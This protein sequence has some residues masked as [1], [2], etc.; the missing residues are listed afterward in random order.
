MIM[1]IKMLA[2]FVFVLSMVFCPVAYCHSLLIEV[3][4]AHVYYK[5]N[6]DEIFLGKLLDLAAD[7]YGKEPH[8]NISIIFDSNIPLDTALNASGI[9]NKAGFQKVVLFARWKKTEKMC[10][11]T[12]G[13]PVSFK[14]N[15]APKQ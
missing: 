11:V 13:M 14:K 2:A 8:A 7:L 12:L 5:L 6:G 4:D 15:L 10:E 3:K 1:R 9:F